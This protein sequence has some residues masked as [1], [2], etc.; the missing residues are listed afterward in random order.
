M[1]PDYWY[2][3]TFVRTLREVKLKFN[4]PAGFTSVGISKADGGKFFNTRGRYVATFWKVIMSKD[5]NT[6]I[7]LLLVAPSAPFYGRVLD[8]IDNVKAPFGVL[9]DRNQ[10][11]R[12]LGKTELAKSGATYGVEFM[13]INAKPF[14]KKFNHHRFVFLASE[15]FDVFMVYFSTTPK[16]IDFYRMYNPDIIERL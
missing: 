14:M 6:A 10:P 15:N 7:G 2:D 1:P 13:T 5:S 9:A 11:F 4:P 12:E 16:L 3:T 8:L